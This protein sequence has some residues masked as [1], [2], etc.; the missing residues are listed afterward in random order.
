MNITMKNHQDSK[1]AADST[2]RAAAALSRIRI[3]DDMFVGW[4]PP[5]PNEQPGGPNEKKGPKGVPR[6]SHK[7]SKTGCQRCRARRVKVPPPFLTLVEYQNALTP[8]SLF[9]TL[10]WPKLELKC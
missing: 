6:L 10:F 4:Q 7:K 3:T 1:D 2:S 8:S 5:P 9:S